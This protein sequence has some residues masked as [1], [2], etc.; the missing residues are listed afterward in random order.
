MKNFRLL[1]FALALTLLTFVACNP[2]NEDEDPTPSEITGTWRA[3]ESTNTYGSQNYYVDISKDSA[4]ANKYYIDNFFN[5]GSGKDLSCTKSGS[6]ISLSS[7]PFEGFVFSGTGSVASNYK[8][9]TWNFTFDDGNG[10]ESGTA[11]YTKL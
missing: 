5:Q 7:A 4:D 1:Q 8:T 9:I 6:S 10:P 2:D 11:T 3:Q